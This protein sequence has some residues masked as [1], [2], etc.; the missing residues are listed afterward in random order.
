MVYLS[1]LE[2]SMAD[3]INAFLFMY[4]DVVL[5]VIL[6][7]LCVYFIILRKQLVKKEKDLEEQLSEIYAK[8]VFDN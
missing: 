8:D 5:F 4:W 1:E 6:A 3:T 7:A 2:A